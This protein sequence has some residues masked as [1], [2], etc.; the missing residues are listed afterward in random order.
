[1]KTGKLARNIFGNVVQIENF[2][3]VYKVGKFDPG[4]ESAAEDL[5]SITYHQ[6]NTK[7][8]VK[9]PFHKNLRPH[10]SN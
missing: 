2:W 3:Y 5:K 4:H 10:V 6:Q 8:I 1:M 7:K 9:L